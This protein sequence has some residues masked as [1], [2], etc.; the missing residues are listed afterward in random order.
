METIE[1]TAHMVEFVF[2]LLHLVG[3]MA[4]MAAL[5]EI[6][7]LPFRGSSGPITHKEKQWLQEIFHPKGETALSLNKTQVIGWGLAEPR[8]L[9][10]MWPEELQERVDE[11]NVLSRDIEELKVRL[12]DPRLD[13]SSTNPHV[14][15]KRLE[16]E[17]LLRQ[18]RMAGV[19]YRMR[20]A[21]DGDT[22][23]LENVRRNIRTVLE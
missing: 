9:E 13:F 3:F 1:I 19:S 4:L 23:L 15:Q 8:E 20:L 12:A 7:F 17:G 16:L 5:I 21:E 22:K 6:A 18:A 10:S 14:V 2:I 11:R